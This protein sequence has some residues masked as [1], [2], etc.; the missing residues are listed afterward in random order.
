[1]IKIRAF[2]LYFNKSTLLT[3][4]LGGTVEGWMTECR[5]SRGKLHNIDSSDDRLLLSDNLRKMGPFLPKKKVAPHS[6]TPLGHLIH[7]LLIH[8]LLFS[9]ARR[10]EVLFITFVYASV[11]WLPLR[12]QRRSGW[13]EGS[14]GS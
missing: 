6:A 4:G 7:D 2:S 13:K 3:G 11:D 5:I 1:M 9:N 12:R 10:T 14:C 8:H